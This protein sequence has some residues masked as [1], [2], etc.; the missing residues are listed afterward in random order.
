[1]TVATN[2]DARKVNQ[3]VRDLRVAAGQVDDARVA[4]G[5]DGERI[6]VG[7]RIVTRRNDTAVGVANRE[8]WTVEAVTGDGAVLAVGGGGGRHVRLDAEYVAG[9]TQLAYAT[10]DYGN[11]GVTADR[12]VTWVSDAT[13]AGGLYVGAT[14]G[15]YANTLHV[16]A[17]DPDDARRRLVAAIGRDRADRGLDAAC[18]GRSRRR[19]LPNRRASR[20]AGR[21]DGCAGRVA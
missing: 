2:S 13:T 15:R 6:G 21:P 1:M 3:A 18:P 16:V 5:V 9:H 11:Q 17:S 19:P 10:T 8:T 12:S 4:V 20:C 7:D 14:R